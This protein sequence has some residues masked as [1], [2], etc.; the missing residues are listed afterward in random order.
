MGRAKKPSFDLAEAHKYFVAH[1]FNT[2]WD[3]IEKTDRTEDEA[4]LMVALNQASIYHWLNRPDV[5]DRNL[6]IG[7]W[8]AS[9]IQSLLGNHTEALHHAEVCLAASQDAA[10]FYLGYAHEA[11]ARAMSGLGRSEDAMRHLRI[12]ASLASGVKDK[13]DREALLADLAT[14]STPG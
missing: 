9:R 13:H 1:C 7:Y 14:I 10:P 5:T 11:L 4:R 6:S 3:L 2:A 8:Q 12:A